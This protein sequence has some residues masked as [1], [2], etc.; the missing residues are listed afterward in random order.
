MRLGPAAKAR[1]LWIDVDMAPSTRSPK[2]RQAVGIFY[3]AARLQ[4][5]LDALI[6]AG[7]D[8]DDLALLAGREMIDS[9]IRPQLDKTR[10][11]I[12]K[13]LLQTMIVV[14]SINEVGPMFIS[15]SRLADFLGRAQE[16]ELAEKPFPDGHLPDRH[17]AFLREQLDAGACL[18]W[19]T[20][21]NPDQ[22]K[23]AGRALLKHSRHRVQM[24]DLVS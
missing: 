10:N 5:T 7:V 9:T 12:L 8:R 19:I 1:F 24:H 23:R 2:L 21:H 4:V 17:A 6:A 13:D 18:L 14:G 20:V 11:P 22:E 16:D 15:R 3:E